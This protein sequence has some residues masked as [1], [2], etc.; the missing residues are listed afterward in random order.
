MAE[1]DNNK[2][3]QLALLSDWTSSAIRMAMCCASRKQPPNEY[4]QLRKALEK[5]QHE[6]RRL[7]EQVDALEKAPT[8]MPAAR[9]AAAAGSD[10]YEQR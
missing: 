6:V 1:P 4:D 9:T 2:P 8:P 10:E 7:Q 5:K 3:F